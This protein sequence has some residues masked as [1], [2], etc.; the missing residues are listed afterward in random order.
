MHKTTVAA[1]GAMAM[2]LLNGVASAASNGTVSFTGEVVANTCTIANG[3]AV[4]VAL[5]KVSTD[6]FSGD[7]SKAGQTRFNIDLT[8]CTPASGQ[9]GVRFT[10]IGSQV[11]M[12]RG[13]FVNTGTATNV[14]VGVFDDTALQLKPAA[15]SGGFVN[16]DTSSG[17][18]S[19]PLDAY[20]VA[21]N[22]TVGAGTVAA[23]GNFE[24]VYK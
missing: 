23:T 3:G 1:C 6:V 13:L 9:V 21:T 17:A 8:A 15:D 10:G 24:L 18:A 2:A 19:I 11:D 7:G 12:T 20:Y 14:A 22:A 4:T 16:V 5:P